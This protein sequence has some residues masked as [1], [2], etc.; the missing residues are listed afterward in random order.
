MK[1]LPILI[2]VIA[3]LSFIISSC[4]NHTDGSTPAREYLD[5]ADIDSL[6]K[7]G[8]DFY[9]YANGRWL[10]TAV[11]PPT[12][13]S[14][15]SFLNIYNRTKSNIRSIL[16]S[17]SS[18]K[19]ADGSIEQK[20]G[21]FYASGLDSITIDKL[22]FDPVK[23][24]LQQI[25]SIKDIQGVLRFAATQ[26][27]IGNSLLLSQYIGADEKNSTLNISIYTQSGLGLPDRDY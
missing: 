13:S 27:T 24:Y 2:I 20:V 19:N 6:V 15:G 25:D 10:K 16:D 9:L 21:D 12:E 1:R 22:G 7:P 23:I 14:V 18:S 17:V 4:S 3:S 26:T 11:I 8:E 5:M